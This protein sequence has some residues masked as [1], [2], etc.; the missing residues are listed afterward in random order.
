MMPIEDKRKVANLLETALLIMYPHDD[1][2]T[3]AHYKE[4]H[5]MLEHYCAEHKLFIEQYRNRPGAKKEGL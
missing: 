1:E 5:K 2:T 3:N 4:L